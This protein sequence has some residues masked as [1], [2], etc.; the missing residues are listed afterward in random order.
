VNC[1]MVQYEQTSGTEVGRQ[2][3]RR[4]KCR[5]ALVSRLI[6]AP[7]PRRVPTTAGVMWGLMAETAVAEESPSAKDVCEGRNLTD[8]QACLE[9]GC[10]HW[11]GSSRSSHVGEGPGPT[12][13]QKLLGLL[14]LFATIST[15][16]TPAGDCTY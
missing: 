9:P 8:E 13:M 15:A 10:C 1:S 16:A 3:C 14:A 12:T 5:E 7:Y 4:E 11:D 6:L 2:G